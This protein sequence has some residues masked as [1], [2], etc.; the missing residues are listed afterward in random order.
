MILKLDD[1]IQGLL[2]T[3]DNISNEIEQEGVF[4][5]EGEQL[6][7]EALADIE[8]PRATA[9]ARS[10]NAQQSHQGTTETRNQPVDETSTRQSKDGTSILPSSVPDRTHTITMVELLKAES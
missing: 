10:A 8:T 6:L 3:K 4:S 2:E 5:N 7:N 1:K 9:Q